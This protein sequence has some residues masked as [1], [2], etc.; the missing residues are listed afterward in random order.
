M[1]SWRGFVVG[2]PQQIHIRLNEEEYKLAQ[3]AYT[4]RLVVESTGDLIK[5][6]GVFVLSNKRGFAL[7]D[8]L[9]ERNK[10]KRLHSERLHSPI[11]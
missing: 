4:D 8:A 3:M 7:Y 1:Q 5:E 6:N 2:K 10:Q 9:N 11:Q